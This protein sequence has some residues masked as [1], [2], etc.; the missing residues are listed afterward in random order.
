M[1]KTKKDS[2]L[3]FTNISLNELEIEVVSL[4]PNEEEQVNELQLDLLDTLSFRLI[5]D[6]FGK[7]ELMKYF[8]DSID[9]SSS[10]L[11]EF[12]EEYENGNKITPI[13]VQ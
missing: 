11:K 13:T 6:G 9:Q 10:Y 3:D 1:S 4:F 8:S 2:I 12:E 7:E 5:C